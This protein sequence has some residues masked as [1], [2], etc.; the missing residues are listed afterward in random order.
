MCASFFGIGSD[1][2]NCVFH[3]MAA[4]ITMKWAN[5]LLFYISNRFQQIIS[6]RNTPIEMISGG[7]RRSLL[8]TR[9]I[10]VSGNFNCQ[11]LLVFKS[12]KLM[13]L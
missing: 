5:V 1:L 13:V 3:V 4:C 8:P 11:C 6:L 2:A 12:S 10:G 7:A 9:M